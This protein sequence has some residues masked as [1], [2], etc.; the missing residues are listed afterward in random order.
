VFNTSIRRPLSSIDAA[1]LA[2]D[3]PPAA[4]IERGVFL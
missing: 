2:I 3:R 4:R 1:P